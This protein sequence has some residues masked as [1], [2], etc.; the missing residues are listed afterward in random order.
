MQSQVQADVW[1]QPASCPPSPLSGAGAFAFSTSPADGWACAWQGIA[2]ACAFADEGNTASGA[3]GVGARAGIG[4]TPATA[5]AAP[6]TTR[7]KQSRQRSKREPG[8]M[9][10]VYQARACLPFR[11]RGRA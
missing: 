5:E 4:S 3:A 8:D 9:R 1:Q 10:P 7:Q 2:L 6:F 11:A